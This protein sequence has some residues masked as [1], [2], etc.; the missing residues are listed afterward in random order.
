MCFLFITMF[1][2]C[3]TGYTKVRVT[4]LGAVFKYLI[5]YQKRPVGAANNKQTNKQIN[6]FSGFLLKKTSRDHLGNSRMIPSPLS[7]LP[8][9]LSLM[10]RGSL[11][12]HDFNSNTLTCDLI[13]SRHTS[14]RQSDSLGDILELKTLVSA[15]T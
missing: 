7:S 1:I 2:E 11:L 12:L 3:V 14:H 5:F 15:V 13:S 8:L 4:V 10:W 6:N 9:F